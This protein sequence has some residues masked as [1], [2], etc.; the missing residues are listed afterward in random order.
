M[1]FDELRGRWDSPE[2]KKAHGRPPREPVSAIIERMERMD[3]RDKRRRIAHQVLMRVVLAIPL[4][5]AAYQLFILKHRDVPVQL[6][7]FVVAMLVYYGLM[8]VDKKMEKYRQ[9]K[10]W[11]NLK[12]FS[13]E[14]VERLGKNIFF[15]RCN[16]A[17]LSVGMLCIP[18]YAVPLISSM[19]RI[20]CFVVIA[21][22]IVVL[23]IYYQR[24]IADLK[25]LRDRNR[26][27]FADL[28]NL[29]SE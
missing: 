4:A 26:D 10:V 1:D 25:D 22:A 14:E 16:A 27:N 23:L 19:M 15:A 9:P 21:A 11:L 8:Q 12:E 2:F 7:A 18:L 17:L 24:R 5:L 3:R 6:A 28:D 29:P 13:L 20:A